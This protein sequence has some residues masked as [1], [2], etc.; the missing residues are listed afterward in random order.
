MAGGEGSA[1]TVKSAMAEVSSGIKNMA[2]DAAA[3]VFGD[4]KAHIIGTGNAT[5]GPGKKALANRA[6]ESRS[7]YVSSDTSKADL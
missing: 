2:T 6:G 3:H 5:R 4:Q 1:G 7:P